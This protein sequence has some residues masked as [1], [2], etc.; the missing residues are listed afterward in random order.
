MNRNSIVA[1]L[2]I[3]IDVLTK[4]LV[5]KQKFFFW[6]VVQNSGLPFGIAL[7][8]FFSFTVAV[9][10][11]AAFVILYYFYFPKSQG[12]LGFALVVGGA[13]GN[14]ADRF[15]HGAVTDF[16]NVGISTINLADLAIMI[17]ILFVAGMAV[18]KPK[19][20]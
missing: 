12:N 3:V 8:G 11:L 16:I 1:L 9:L 13:L 15:V 18:R 2:V 20:T 19:S 5:R 4:E 17:G 7:P 10:A 14:L 6:R